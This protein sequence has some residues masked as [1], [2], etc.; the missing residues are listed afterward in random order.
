M[1]AKNENSTSN[2]NTSTDTDS[3]VIF[4]G[5]SKNIKVEAQVH[6]PECTPSPAV[7]PETPEKDQPS[8]RRSFFYNFTVPETQQSPS[9]GISGN[10]YYITL[11]LKKTFFLF[12]TSKEIQ[13]KRLKTAHSL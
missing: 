9:S 2:Q 7:I 4:V 13:V 3:S 6:N 1:D 8:H 5:L 11:T 10:I 12:L